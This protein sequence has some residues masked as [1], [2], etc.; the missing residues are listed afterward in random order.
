MPT[1]LLM[2]PPF[3]RS[4]RHHYADSADFLHFTLLPVNQEDHH[5]PHGLGYWPLWLRLDALLK[6]IFITEDQI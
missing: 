2:A 6:L 5:R 3:H 1:W 4:T